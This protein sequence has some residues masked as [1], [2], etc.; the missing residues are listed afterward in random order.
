MGGSR[1][2]AVKKAV[3]D[4]LAAAYGA[5]SDFNG[6][7]S[8]EH[9]VEV[10]YGWHENWKAAEKV[11]ATSARG[12][13]P[14]AAMRSG[15]NHRDESGTFELVILVAALDGDAWEAEDR[16]MD[17]GTVAEEWIADRKSGELAAG[18]YSLRITDW[19]LVSRSNVKGHLAELT[20]T[21][22]WTARL[23]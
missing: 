10:K 14:P 9:V 2:V 23:T 5:L 12:Q 8:A 17:I 11:F 18:N 22:A 19:V 13:T 15:R 20:Y 7:T 4:G 1:V 16:A 3:M 21:V 6:T